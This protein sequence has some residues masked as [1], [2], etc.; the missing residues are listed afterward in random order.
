[1]PT[2]NGDSRDISRDTPNDTT[3]RTP[4]RR[5]EPPAKARYRATHPT[6]GVTVD[7]ATYERLV[8]LRRTTGLSFGKLVLQ[9]LGE[10]E[11]QV[12]LAVEKGRRAGL[13]EGETAG[14][15]KARK[16]LLVEYFCN[17]CAE[18]LPL[19]PGTKAAEVAIAELARHGWGHA[20]CHEAQ[21]AIRNT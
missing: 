4:G 6:I 3:R 8:E 13:R 9:A 12:G 11:G 2:P 7:R 1:M 16:E 5:H 20:K 17:V 14:Y 21:R 15:N 19:E 18:P 10:I